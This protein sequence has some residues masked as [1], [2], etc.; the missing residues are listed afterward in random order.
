M[1]IAYCVRPMLGYGGDGVQ[2][3]KTKE[4]IEKQYP[5]AEVRILESPEELDA[6]YDIVHIFNY[7]TTEIARAYF[8]K[9]L[10][11]KLKIVSSPIYWDYSYSIM[12]LYMYMWCNKTFISE[13]F[14]KFHRCLQP[15]VSR[16]PKSII[17]DAYTNV[18]SRFSKEIRF[19]IDS[20]NLIL[21]N[22]RE[23]GE[24][25]CKFAK[26]ESGLEKIRVVYNGVDVKDVKILEEEEF[27]SKYKIP[28]GFVLQVGRI[29]Y[30]KNP[31]NLINALSDNPEI[32]IVLLGGA[33]DY[34]P[35]FKQI[36]KIAAKR[37]NVYFVEKVP[38]DDVYSFYYYANV[39]VL[40]SMRESPGL[41]SLEA[42]S[43]GCPIVISDERFLPL[44]TYFH[45]HYESVNPYDREQ[46]KKAVLDSYKKG[47]KE[48]DLSEFS[49][50]HVAEMTYNAYLE[51]LNKK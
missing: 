46:I 36:K 15:I 40:L 44:S 30:L 6:S 29:E 22:S 10:S 3:L 11:L 23:E 2:V 34:S 9:A 19:F 41:V 33:K 28:H 32:P 20:S 17:K 16:L 4:N 8:E 27:F 25:C 51:V 42:L 37:G 5:N 45:D 43:Q 1:K 24:L 7:S 48:I 38:H 39:H 18:S 21:P 49:W 12:P 14:V 35:Y 13:R 47:H 26:T 31:M 50:A